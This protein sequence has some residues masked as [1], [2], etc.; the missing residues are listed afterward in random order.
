MFPATERKSSLLK[1]SEE[2]DKVFED[3]FNPIAF[4]FYTAPYKSRSSH[5]DWNNG[6][7]I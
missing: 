3:G 2:F 1:F 5:S 6:K 4:Y 7:A